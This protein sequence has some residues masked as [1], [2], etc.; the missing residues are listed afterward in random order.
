MIVSGDSFLLLPRPQIPFKFDS[1]AIFRNSEASD[2]VL[3]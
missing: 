1:F 2:T 3:T